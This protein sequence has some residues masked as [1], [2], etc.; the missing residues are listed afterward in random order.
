MMLNLNSYFKNVV[1]LIFYEDIYYSSFNTE[2]RPKTKDCAS[3]YFCNIASM[4]IGQLTNFRFFYVFSI[5]IHLQKAINFPI[6]TD[7]HRICKLVYNFIFRNSIFHDFKKSLTF[8]FRAPIV[9]FPQTVG[10]PT[11]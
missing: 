1:C 5:S 9:I 7:H 2:Y 11:H 10:F 6:D 3:D 8:F 4:L